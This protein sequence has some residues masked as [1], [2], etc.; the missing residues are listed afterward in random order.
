MDCVICKTPN[1]VIAKYCKQCGQQFNVDTQAKTDPSQPVS[2]VNLDASDQLI[3]L[4]ELKSQFKKQISAAVNMRRAG[5]T[6]DNKNLNTILAGDSG[7]GKNKVV[8]VMTTLFFKNGI[9]TRADVTT[10]SAAEFQDFSKDVKGNLDRAKG[11]IL[12]IDNVHQLVPAGY[13]P[14]QSTPID[15]LYAEMEGRPADPIIFL[16]SR[17]N[18]FREYLKAN[19]EVNNRFDLKFYLPAL[20]LDQMVTLANN[21]LTA[22]HY[23]Q[24]EGFS[25]KLRNRM[26]YLFRN[27]N[28]IERAVRIGK[29]GYLVNKEV[30]NIISDHFA[31]LD[32]QYPPT[33]LLPADIKGEVYV[34]RSATDVLLDLEDFVGMDAVK[35]FVADLVKLTA[36]QQ[37]DSAGGGSSDVISAHM[38][39]T[40][41][42]GTGKTTLAKKLGEIFAASGILSSGHVIEVDRSKLVGQYVGETP[43]LVQKACDEAMG[44]VL[45]I[46]EAYTMMQNDQDTYGRE[47]IDTLIKRLEDDRGKFIMIAA[48]Y[49]RPM[50][51]FIDANPGMKSRVKGNIF[52][53]PDYNAQ[54]ML[55]ILQGFVKRAGFIMNEATTSKAAL[56]LEEMYKRR[57]K[58]FGN[59]RDVRNFY[60]SMLSRRA[61]R[62]SAQISGDYDKVFL[63]EDLGITDQDITESSVSS[64]MKDLN[65]L[66]GLNGVKNQISELI[67]FLQGEKLRAAAGNK[68]MSINLHFVFSGNPGTGK[69][70]V[71]RLLAKIF[72][73]LGVLPTDKLVEV[74][75]KD[76]VS[77]YVGQTSAQTNKV[78]DSAMGGVLFIDEA[79]TLSKGIASGGGGFGSEAIDTLLKRMEDDRGKFIVIAAGYSKEMQDI[80]DSNPGLDS[81][82]SKKIIFE[83][84]GPAEL[85]KIMRSMMAQNGFTADELSCQK[86]DAYLTDIYN[87]RDKRFANARTVRNTFENIVQIQSRRI[88]KQKNSGLAFDAV[89]ITADDIPF[90]ET[91]TISSKDALAELNALIGLKSVKDEINGLISFLE[92]E[93]MRVQQGASS[94]NMLNLHFLFKGRPGT[95]KTTVARILAKVFKSL[96]VLP[97]GQ[98]I[99]TDRKDLVGQYVGHTAKQTSEVIDKAIGGVL[100][101]DEAY[102]LIP[103]G[104][105]NDF[106]KEAVDTLLKRMED[107]KGK[108][109]VIAA[110]YSDDMDRF[111][112]SN[113]GLASRFPKT[114]MFDDYDP[115][116]LNQIFTQML[117]KNGLILVE[118]DKGKVLQMFTEMYQTRDSKFANGRTVRNLF[119]RTL[120]NQAVRLSHIKQ[121]GGDISAGINEIIYDDIIAQ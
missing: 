31:S 23:Q 29:G 63:P 97:V 85:S 70:T 14:G 8:E 114:V 49:E 3:G 56:I 83:D 25:E 116:E 53:L 38:I 119:E 121:Q 22:Q 103:Q 57:G 90:A 13:Q 47:A 34:T 36:V 77:G 64:V 42:P 68:G 72:K 92:I 33:L 52:N 10:I 58:D 106:G 44:G 5:F 61:S 50:Q 41:N 69:T 51:N 107:D 6:Y 81:R 120:E 7:T 43:L 84:Y 73:G 30:N 39:L 102:T 118:S 78:I 94:K 101:I 100:F 113:E 59:A 105:P 32:P 2:S 96:Q 86:I 45:F 76:L 87:K 89:A 55:L 62:L 35:T 11:G 91:D 9:T 112:A 4:D 110:G 98:L 16:L 18:G 12:V 115:H 40:G 46:D 27:Q 80:L 93:K 19:P 88:V 26:A 99:E 71:A 95:G 109:I 111:V 17:E 79:Y 48:G 65:Q 15:K 60:E 117:T 82:F 37:R 104:N 75:D 20:T 1:R 21:L 24:H 67:D 28:D 74:T 66:I 108:F 54:Q